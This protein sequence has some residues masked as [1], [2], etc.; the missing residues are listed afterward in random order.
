MMVQEKKRIRMYKIESKAINY[1]FKKNNMIIYN[2]GS[3]QK[4]A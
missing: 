2:F 3:V 4:K 1:K